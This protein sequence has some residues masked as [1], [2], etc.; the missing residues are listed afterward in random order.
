MHGQ[1]TRIKKENIP[2]TAPK[3]KIGGPRGGVRQKDLI[4]VKPTLARR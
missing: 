3:R 4:F 2:S 1:P